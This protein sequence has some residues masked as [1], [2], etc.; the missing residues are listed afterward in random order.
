[1]IYL[2][3]GTR[4]NFM[5]V[6]PVLRELAA[7]GFATRLM[8]TGQHF[9]PMMSE[10]FFRDLGI[11]EPEARLQAGGGTHAEQTATVLVGVEKDLSAH[12]PRV[13]VVVGD[14]TSTMAAALAAAKLGIPVVHV[15]AGLRSRDWTMPEEINRVV[16]D[17][18]A[19]LLLTSSPE[20]QENLLAEGI[21]RERIH[22]VGNVMMDS[23]AWARARPTQAL[24][25][26]GLRA[27]E[28]ALATLHR[29]A[30]VDSSVSL[31]ATLEALA[32]IAS[33]VPLLFPVHP[34]TVARAEALGQGERLRSTPGLRATEPI[35][36]ND[37][38]TLMS[39]ARLVATDSGGIQE[40]ST[41]L[42]IPC[43]T[44]RQGTERPITVTEG[45]SV[46]VG[47]DR[48]K[49]AREVD[50]I[51]RGRGKRGRVP[52]GWDGRAA[53]RIAD[54]IRTP[55]GGGPA[56]ADGGGAGMTEPSEADVIRNWA[57]HQT[58]LEA[59]ERALQALREVGV[60]P[61]VVKGIVLAYELYDDVALRPLSDVDLRVRPHEF[62]RAARALL[63]RGWQIDFASSQLG[64]VGFYV[65]PTLVE[66]EC[67]VGP[68]GLC[69]LSVARMAARSRRRTLPSG[70]TIREPD[71]VDHA[72]LL[73]VNAFKDKLVDCPTWSVDDLVAM[74]SHPEF[75][76][77][78]FLTRVREAR[79]HALTWIVADWLARER[80]SVQWGAICEAMHSGP[81]RPLYTWALRRLRERA[82]AS[83][84]TRVLARLGSDA[85]ASCVAAA[86]ATGA[87]TA[88]SWLGARVATAI[89]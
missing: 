79:A 12:R 75:D 55:A 27:G 38:V 34:R 14:V 60:E 4:P 33:R 29:P 77:E 82:P 11:A 88:V 54:S 86:L 40:E 47:L 66:L 69:G 44:M 39:G 63:M 5:K 9:D 46:I 59:L 17:R 52:E 80:G 50:A 41:A 84:A 26:F 83:A 28:Y 3:A 67:T 25:R 30:N 71:L 89:A 74:A 13:V 23:L 61:I 56:P 15:E 21:A 24:E 62:M 43:L 81:R 57:I 32:T 19:D 51:L 31:A 18:I 20:A 36:Y 42:G 1:M 85:P 70:L 65:G 7:R 6:A 35:G 87:G 78:V 76:L 58:S 16:T 22:F 45:T 37:F 72:V 64:A 8:H 68:P 2:V 53:A 73:V 10:V 48:E 49:I